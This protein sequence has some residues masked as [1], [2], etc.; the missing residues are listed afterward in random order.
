MNVPHVLVIGGG[1]AGASV[2][3]FASRLG[4]RVT[5]VDAGLHAASGV[6]S[7]LVNPVRGQSGAVD[8]RAV[9]GLRLTWQLVEMLESAGHATPHGRTGVLRPVPDERAR[10]RFERNLPSELPHSWLHPEDVPVP[11]APGWDHALWLPEG[12]WL[13]GAAFTAG[14]VAASGS[15]VVRARAVRRN[16]RSVTLE[17]GKVLT[18]DA[19]VWCG[20]SVGASWAG[21]EATHRAGTLLTLDRTVTSVPVSFGAYLTPAAVGGVLGATFEA[22]TST[23]ERPLLPLRSLGWLL[24]KADALTDLSGARVVGRWS[25][26]RLSGLTVGQETDG[27]WRLSGLGSKGFLLGPLLARH[28]AGDVM[29]GLG[30]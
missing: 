16:A 18:G 30:M 14:L 10:G 25:G 11:L 28:M 3:H 6:P 15:E 20:G 29:R 24:S 26:T 17:D 1:V 4:A 8:A 27:V 22:P 19:V 7:A 21:E 23:W 9:E 5:V 12:G 13:D 2:A